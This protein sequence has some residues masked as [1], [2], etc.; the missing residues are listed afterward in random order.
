MTVFV[1]VAR[2]EALRRAWFVITPLEDSEVVN[3]ADAASVG[4]DASCVGHEVE[5]SGRAIRRDFRKAKGF[6]S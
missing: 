6:L 5:D 3:E 4:T 2:S 1:L